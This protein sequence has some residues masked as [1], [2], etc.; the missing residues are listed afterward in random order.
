VVVGNAAVK[1]AGRSRRAYVFGAGAAVPQVWRMA[2]AQ[3]RFLPADDPRAARA[4][5]VLGSRVRG[6]LFPDVNPLGRRIRIGGERYRVVGVMAA[7]GQMLGFDLDDAVYIPAGRALGMFNR[8][9]LMEIDI[10][11]TAGSRSDEIA[12]RITERLKA[13]HGAED[14]TVVTQDQMLEILG[15]VLSVLTAAVG[16]LGGISLFVGGVGILTIMTIAVRERTAEIGV[17]RALG[18][19]RGHV[20]GLFLAEA[21]VLAMI[22]GLAGLGFGAGG[23]WLLGW[24]VPALPTHTSW[25]YVASA[26]G[27]AVLIG[28]LAGVVPAVQ[29]AR[30]DPV[31]ALRTE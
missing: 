11:Y 28:V 1:H 4:L 26:E 13:R 16:A 9:S 22:G 25:F 3:G 23:A 31:E 6:E 5:A 12:R 21:V 15:S 27:L 29:A 10:L 14:F 20:A 24:L 8:E 19:G 7:K 30:L 2:V 18:A 17:L